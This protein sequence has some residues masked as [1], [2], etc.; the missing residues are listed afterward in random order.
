L[1]QGHSG[2]WAPFVLVVGILKGKK[3]PKSQ[4]K[5]EKV[6]RG[7]GA[8]EKKSSYLVIKNSPQHLRS[9]APRHN[10]GSSCQVLIDL[11]DDM[12][13]ANSQLISVD[14]LSSAWIRFFR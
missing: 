11:T 6:Q 3:Y 1:G 14:V 2:I 13:S 7:G 12:T 4:T 9:P 10:T 8:E 5:N